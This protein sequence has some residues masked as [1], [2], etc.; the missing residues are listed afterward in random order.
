MSHQTPGARSTPGVLTAID[1]AVQET[2]SCGCGRKL[3]PN[4]PSEWFATEACQRR[5]QARQATKPG[6]VLAGGRSEF[7]LL[8]AII[9]ELDRHEVEMALAAARHGGGWSAEAELNLWRPTVTR[10][11]IPQP[12]GHWSG[13]DR[14]RLQ[15]DP[16]WRP[17]EACPLPFRRRCLNCNTAVGVRDDLQRRATD[18]RYAFDGSVEVTYEPSPAQLCVRCGYVFPLPL[19][20]QWRKFRQPG[21]PACLLRLVAPGGLALTWRVEPP[22]EVTSPPRAEVIRLAELAWCD[23][24]SAVVHE[25]TYRRPCIADGCGETGRRYFD[26]ARRFPLEIDESTGDGV[27]VTRYYPI[28]VG[29]FW[30]CPRHESDLMRMNDPWDGTPLL[31]FDLLG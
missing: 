14:L 5:Y 30:L 3:K 18:V 12:S 29:P 21:D 13:D 16:E 11:P 9:A 4:G 20:A 1:A 19:L 23:A 31:S 10:L 26:A 25:L 28:P 6:E 2:C 7:D 22:E 24:E 15:L 17:A 8:D 27:R